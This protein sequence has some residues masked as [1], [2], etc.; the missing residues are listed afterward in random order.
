MAYWYLNEQN[1]I[2]NDYLPEPIDDVF[3]PPYPATFWYYTEGENKLVLD[4]LPKIGACMGCTSLT[5]VSIPKSIKSIGRYS[6][7]DTALTNVTIARDCTYYPT[8]FP[9]NCTVNFYPD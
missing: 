2:T 3:S 6:F 8:S 5:D 1:I 7:A 9:D 4:M